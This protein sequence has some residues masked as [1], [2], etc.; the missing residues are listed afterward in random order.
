MPKF[1]NRGPAGLYNK[2]RNNNT[3][4]QSEHTN[5][6][7][8]INNISKSLRDMGMVVPIDSII[9]D[10]QNARQ[11]PER[12][13]EAIKQSLTL[14]GQNQPI[15]VLR[16][17]RKILA[18]NGR[19]ECMKELGWTECAVTWEDYTDEEATGFSLAD[20]RTA[21]L[22]KWNTKVLSALQVLQKDTGHGGIGWT[23]DELKV[24]RVIAFEDENNNKQESSIVQQ[25][26]AKFSILVQCTNE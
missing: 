16:S 15:V 18:G 6:K 7:C 9:N 19:W 5:K 14:Y 12:N 23:L 13:K 1:V 24:L 2:L 11:H 20:N 25:D 8:K 22:A 26:D 17:N 21:E 3:P 4:S 10:P